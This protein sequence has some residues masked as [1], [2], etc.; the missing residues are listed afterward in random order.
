MNRTSRS[1]GICPYAPIVSF[2]RFLPVY[3]ARAGGAC[4]RAL[5]VD[6]RSWGNGPAA[7]RHAGSWPVLCSEGGT[8]LQCGLHPSCRDAGYTSSIQVGKARASSN[9]FVSKS[10]RF[11]ASSAN[12]L[13]QSP[14]PGTYESNERW[15][16]QQVLPIHPPPFT[17]PTHRASLMLGSRRRL[18]RVDRSGVL[19]SKGE[20][21]PKHQPRVVWCCSHRQ[22]PFC[23]RLSSATQEVLS[24]ASR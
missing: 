13:D 3:V 14:G 6:H 17:T 7:F 21:I 9:N 2:C 18:V 10:T 5:L 8:L 24:S 11:K 23:T 20:S 22:P 1:V 19:Q 12:A 4:G 15:V 16:S